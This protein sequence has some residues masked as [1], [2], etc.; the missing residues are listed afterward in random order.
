[1]VYMNMTFTA[2]GVIDIASAALIFFPFSEPILMYMMVYMLAKGGFFLTTGLASRSMG[3]HCILLC[4]SDILVGLALGAI[5]LGYG[6]IVTAGL[7]GTFIKT[8]G[9]VGV[10]KGIYTTAFPI[11]S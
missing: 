5:A 6:S 1:M 7:V 4:V 9:W 2:L 11:F 10:V 8:V 3:P